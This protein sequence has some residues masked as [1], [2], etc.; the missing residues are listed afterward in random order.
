MEHYRSILHLVEEGVQH[1]R[2]AGMMS[3]GAIG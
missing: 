3:R 1:P 2:E